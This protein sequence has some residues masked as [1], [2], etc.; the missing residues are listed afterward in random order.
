M[1]ICLLSGSQRNKEVKEHL[2]QLV[3]IG[4]NIDEIYEKGYLSSYDYELLKNDSTDNYFRFWGTRDGVN[5]VLANKWALME[6]GDLVLFQDG[7]HFTYIATVLGISINTNL[8]KLIKNNDSKDPW[9]HIIYLTHIIKVADIESDVIFKY[10]GYDPNL[11]VRGLT[12]VN[13]PHAG[14]I[15][16]YVYGWKLTDRIKL[17][18]HSYDMETMLTG[19][20]SVLRK[21]GLKVNVNNIFDYFKGRLEVSHVEPWYGKIDIITKRTIKKL[22]DSLTSNK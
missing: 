21:E 4:F 8:S 14:L 5:N 6:K 2:I 12:I 7:E 18:G 1:Q 3:E 16:R 22:L 17:K 9:N 10:V 20:I 13:T 11:V 19:T 15:R